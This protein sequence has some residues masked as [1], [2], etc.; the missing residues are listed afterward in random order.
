MAK[1]HWFGGAGNAVVILRSTGQVLNDVIVRDKSFTINTPDLGTRTIKR[2]R[3][4]TIVY[5]N[6]PSYPTDM[7]R[8]L[9]GTELNGVITNDPV[10]LFTQDLG[11]VAV[12]KANLLS[13]IW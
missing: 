11:E 9:D 2:E 6:L 3:I 13:I 12:P 5:K 4:K 8:I 10:T 1:G 7:L